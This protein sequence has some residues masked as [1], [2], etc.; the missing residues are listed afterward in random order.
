MSSHIEQESSQSENNRFLDAFKEGI[1]SQ[2]A[3]LLKWLGR[4]S[5]LAIP[6]L[7][8]WFSSGNVHECVISSN[9]PVIGGV[10]TSVGLA[11]LLGNPVISILAGVLI[12]LILKI[13]FIQHLLCM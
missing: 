8:L 4:V 11:L 7:V 2:L 5:V 13:P 3:I 9:I 6:I 1:R 12:G 10:I